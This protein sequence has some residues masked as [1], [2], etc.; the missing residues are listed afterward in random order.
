MR[1][2]DIDAVTEKLLHDSFCSWHDFNTVMH[3]LDEAPTIDAV[4]VKHGRWID[5]GLDLVCSACGIRYSDELPYM[6]R[7]STPGSW[8]MEGFEYCPHCGAKMD[9]ERV[10]KN[11]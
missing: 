3:A 9:G 6:S 4:P 10:K 5:K 7:L 11:G 1:L 2:G 8:D